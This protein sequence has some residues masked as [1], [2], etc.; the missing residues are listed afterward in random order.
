MAKEKGFIIIEWDESGVRLNGGDPNL[1]GNEVYRKL[2][3]GLMICIMS[4]PYDY[5]KKVIYPDIDTHI[6]YIKNCKELDKNGESL[7]NIKT[8]TSTKH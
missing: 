1:P 3:D 2:L 7:E 4:C 6:S 5:Y 8:P